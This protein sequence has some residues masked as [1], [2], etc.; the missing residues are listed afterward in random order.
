[1]PLPDNAFLVLTRHDLPSFLIRSLPSYL[2]GGILLCLI[3]C[4]PAA[5]QY[6]SVFFARSLLHRLSAFPTSF[7]SERHSAFQ[8][9]DLRFILRHR[10]FLSARGFAA[11]ARRSSFTFTRLYSP[12]AG[13]RRRRGSLP[14]R[15]PQDPRQNLPWTKPI[16]SRA[17]SSPD[18]ASPSASKVMGKS[19]RQSPSS[20]KAHDFDSCRVLSVLDGS[21]CNGHRI[22]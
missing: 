13:D 17:V 4:H 14:C 16:S 9:N 8:T 11:P 12:R 19:Q 22:E 6:E 10:R 1:M 5:N 15:A 3:G 7:E 20:V 18:H 2:R 21:T